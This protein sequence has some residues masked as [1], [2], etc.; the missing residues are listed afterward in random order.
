M[1]TREAEREAGEENS[2]RGL[3]VVLRSPSLQA[4][5]WEAPPD[6]ATGNTATEGR[7]SL[8]DLLL[9][10]RLLSPHRLALGAGQVLVE[11]GCPVCGRVPSCLP[12]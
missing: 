1:E 7:T 8:L 10:A 5:S 2:R 4:E 12:G 6:V 9:Q 11:G 3:A